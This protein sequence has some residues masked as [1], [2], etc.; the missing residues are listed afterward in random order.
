MARLLIVDDDE[1]I[2]EIMKNALIDAGFDTE[3]AVCGKS[4]LEK[5]EDGAFDLLLTDILMPD[6][7]GLKVIDIAIEK[8]PDICV[9]AISGGGPGK[10]GADLLD[11][12]LSYGAG[13]V[14]QKPFRP[15]ELI[16][17]VK[18]LVR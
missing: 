7:C 16:R 2:L 3:S 17:T 15:D 12:A 4:A 1:I 5:L 18:A 11:A 6:I 10:D 9:L 8:N 13:A 14:L